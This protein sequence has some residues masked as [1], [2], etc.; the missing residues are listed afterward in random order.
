[1]VSLFKLIRNPSKVVYLLDKLHLGWLI[2]DKIYLQ[3]KYKAS[4][5][6][7]MDLNNPI[8]FNE[9]LN[10]LKLYDHKPEYSALVD[11]YE[12]KRIVAEKIGEEFIITTLGVWEKFECID[13]DK[14]P[15]QFVLKCT[16]DSGGIVICRNKNEFDIDAAKK[17]INK[18]LKKNYYWQGREW[19]YKDIPR[20]II[21][22]KYMTDYSAVELKD[23]KIFCF[24]GEPKIVLVCT[25]R[26]TDGGLRENFYDIKWNLL[27]I[28]RPK[29]PNTEYSVSKPESLEE[30]LSLAQTLSKN[31]PF[32]RVDFYDVHGKIYFGEMTFYPASG[33][34]GFVPEEWDYKLGEWIKLPDKN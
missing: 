22:E 13:F 8:T 27:N 23:Y 17:K 18:C 10:W 24:N 29:H 12:V 7:K 19:P 6:K 1:M 21:A 28:Q 4:F 25:E 26:F 14:L 31:I 15:N 9:K 2:P 30:M 3:M 33:F 34:E 20:K 5:G 16:H 11:K 32:V